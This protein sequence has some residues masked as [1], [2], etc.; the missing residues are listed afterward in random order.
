MNEVGNVAHSLIRAFG[1]C[2]D[3]GFDWQHRLSPTP[4]TDLYELE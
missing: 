1:T 2:I 4:H 3:K